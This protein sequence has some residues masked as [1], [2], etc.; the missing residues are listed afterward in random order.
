MQYLLT[1]DELQKL[2]PAAAHDKLKRAIEWMRKCI[3]D[4][5]CIHT[6]ELSYCSECP[7]GDLGEDGPPA[8]LRGSVCAHVKAYSK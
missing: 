6:G 8:E 1:E 5:R 3:I 7:L 4:G 2:V